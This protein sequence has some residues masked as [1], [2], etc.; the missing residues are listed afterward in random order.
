MPRK[1]NNRKKLQ[2]ERRKLAEELCARQAGK[3]RFASTRREP[4]DR[5]SFNRIGKTTM[6]LSPLFLDEC[7]RIEAMLKKKGPTDADV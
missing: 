4:M 1:A 7:L 2:K 6:A 5:L 3:H